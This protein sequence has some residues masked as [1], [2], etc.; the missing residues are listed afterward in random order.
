MKESVR[1]IVKQ[2]LTNYLETN[3]HRKTP[4]RFAILDTIYSING[5][6]TLEELGEK[7]AEERNF[8]GFREQQNMRRATIITAIA[9]RYVQYAVK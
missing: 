2:I 4:E 5:H 8:P 7:L 6:F 9:I 1:A 3:S